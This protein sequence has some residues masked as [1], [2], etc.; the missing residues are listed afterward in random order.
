MA[1]PRRSPVRGRACVRASASSSD[2]VALSA[3]PS[4]RGLL[5]GTL[6]ATIALPSVAATEAKPMSPVD[7]F[8]TLMDA[9]DA[10]VS[11][12]ELQGTEG[13]KRARVQNLLPRY[14][15]KAKTMTAAL[16]AAVI[17][18]YGEV[19]SENNSETSGVSPDKMGVMEDAPFEDARAF[20]HLLRVVMTWL[21]RPDH[22]A[23]ACFSAL[24]S[25]RSRSPRWPRR[26]RNRCPP[27][28][29]SSR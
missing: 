27:L 16:P 12:M 29:R 18:A 21:Y 5:L 13:G 9:R 20:A 4:R 25:L 23:E 15:D 14:A 3:G 24:W 26:R 6:V 8:I 22:L 19:V 10:L 28:M 2:D 17:A 7:A 1:G 11:A